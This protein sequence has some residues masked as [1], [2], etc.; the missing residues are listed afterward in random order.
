MTSTKELAKPVIAAMMPAKIGW[1]VP[2]EG[3]ASDQ[4]RVRPTSLDGAP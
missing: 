4:F 1:A 3:L 2:A